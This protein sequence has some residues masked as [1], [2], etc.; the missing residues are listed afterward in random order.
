MAM[1]P[2]GLDRYLDAWVQHAAAGTVQGRKQLASLLT[3]FSSDVR[4]E[5]VPSAA[6]FEGHDGIRRMCETANQWSPDLEFRVLSRQTDG[7]MFSFETETS[8]I[9]SSPLGGLP[10]TGRRFVLRAVAVGRVD[11]N[12]LVC[13]H[14]DYWDLGSFLTQI[15]ALPPLG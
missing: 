7:S 10:A 11:D 8:G 1:D 9:N 2:A 5:D 4:Y 15:G 6:V 3:Y 13:E 12:G 14:R